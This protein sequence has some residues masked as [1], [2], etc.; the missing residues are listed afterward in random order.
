M[1]P[2]PPDIPLA[3]TDSVPAAQPGQTA[4][5]FA[6]LG[7]ETRLGLLTRL[8]TDGPLSIARLTAGT[9][10]T[11]QAITKHLHVLASAGLA[12]G[13]RRGREQFWAVEPESLEEARRCLD[14]ISSQWDDALSRL[15]QHVEDE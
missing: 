12:R 1:S 13:I 6:A 3:T 14:Q 5:I 11:R 10:V 9:A 2:G 8:G 7:D 4:L 15:K